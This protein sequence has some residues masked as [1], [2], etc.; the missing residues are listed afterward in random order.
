[1]EILEIYEKYKI[2]KHL[3]LHQFR[4][5]AVA[6][7]IIDNFSD[8]T[9][10]KIDSKAI[11]SACLLHDIG[12]IIKFNLT[13]YPA[14]NEP[15]GY[16]YWKGVQDEFISKYGP[17]EHAATIKICKEIGVHEYVLEILKSI[18]FTN[19]EYVAKSGNYNLKIVAY[20]DQRV[21][22]NGILS[23][24]KRHAEGRER[25]SKRKNASAFNSPIEEFNRLAAFLADVEK[26][27]FKHCKIKPED[28]NDRSTQEV[29]MDLKR[30]RPEISM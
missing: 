11:I 6:K 25:Y 29:I 24:E 3:Q 26:Q 4:V 8:E 1:M 12:N 30:Y 27:I 21:G 13:L 5:A 9:S 2:P 20:A 15:E 10:I 14:L 22:I 17:D 28:I 16:N 7:L 18:G 19:S 23:M